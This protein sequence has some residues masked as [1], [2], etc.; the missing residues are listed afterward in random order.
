MDQVQTLSLTSRAFYNDVL[1]EYEEYITGLFGYDKV[2]PMNT[3][4]EGGETAVKLARCDRHHLPG[5]DERSNAPD[6]WVT[7][8]RAARAG[9]PL[10]PVAKVA[11]VTE[12]S[13]M[14]LGAACA[15][16]SCSLVLLN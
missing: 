13:G 8:W 1:G 4:V 15:L 2:L 7:G 10:L 3:G 9:A 5:S 14:R 12:W 6:G 16:W 11:G